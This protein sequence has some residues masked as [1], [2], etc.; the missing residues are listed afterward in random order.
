[1]LLGSSCAA[2]RLARAARVIAFSGAWRIVCF[3]APYVPVCL[4][5]VC[6]CARMPVCPCS[7]VPVFLCAYLP[8]GVGALRRRIK[9]EK[10]NKITRRDREISGV[11]GKVVYFIYP[12]VIRS[13]CLRDQYV[14][15]LQER[16]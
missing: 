16:A 1:M 4:C 15:G 14:N 8:I 7:C 13:T 6:P 3:C 11:T 2:L 12:N 5:P 10:K 9:R